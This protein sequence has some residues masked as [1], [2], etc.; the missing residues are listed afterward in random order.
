MRLN[1]PEIK[2]NWNHWFVGFSF[3]NLS[4]GIRFVQ[5]YLGPI[6]FSVCY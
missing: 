3:V 1:N 4:T 5:L 6:Q 2:T